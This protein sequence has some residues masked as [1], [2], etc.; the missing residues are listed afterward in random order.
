MPLLEPWA[1]KL[2]VPLPDGYDREGHN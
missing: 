2:G 1:V